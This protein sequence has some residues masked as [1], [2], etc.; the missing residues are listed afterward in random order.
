VGP[1]LVGHRADHAGPEDDVRDRDQLFGVD[2]PKLLTP[3]QL[4][5]QVG[6]DGEGRAGDAVWLEEDGRRTSGPPW[7]GGREMC[8]NMVFAS[9]GVSLA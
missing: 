9:C 8:S 7:P 5:A 1:L 6:P 4:L 3:V 2:G